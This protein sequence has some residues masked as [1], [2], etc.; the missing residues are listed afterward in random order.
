MARRA[1]PPRIEPIMIHIFFFFSGSVGFFVNAE[2]AGLGGYNEAGARLEETVGLMRT[3][4]LAET[5]G[6]A[7]TAGLAE[8]SG[9]AETDKLEEAV[10]LWASEVDNS[11]FFYNYC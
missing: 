5:A 9:L 1:E 10:R 2:E 7:E 8:T 6:F 3:V 4:G 11:I